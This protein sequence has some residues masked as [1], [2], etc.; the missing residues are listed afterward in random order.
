MAC[1]EQRVTT[2][3]DADSPFVGRRSEA[4]GR[5]KRRSDRGSVLVSD[6]VDDL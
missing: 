4:D 3:L 1:D 2:S 5:T 6:G